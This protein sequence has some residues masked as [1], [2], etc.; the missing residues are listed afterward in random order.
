MEKSNKNEELEE[1]LIQAGLR[2]GY[3]TLVEGVYDP[4][5]LK[6]VFLAGGPGS[7]KSATADTVFNVTP[8]VKS[9]SSSGLKV[10]NSDSTFEHLLKMAG[11]SLDLGSLDDDVFKQIMI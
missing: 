1:T 7:G 6:A 8:E 4:G 10:V 5:I 9:L 11:H 2:K 3:F